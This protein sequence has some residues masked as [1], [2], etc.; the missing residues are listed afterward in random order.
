MRDIRKK[1]RLPKMPKREECEKF[2]DL[3]EKDC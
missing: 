2:P 1:K 3:F